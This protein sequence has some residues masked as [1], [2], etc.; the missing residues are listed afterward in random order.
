MQDKPWRN[1]ELRECEEA[2]PSL[3]ESDMEKASRL[4]KAK[5]GAGKR[6]IPPKSSSGR[7]KKKREGKLWN[8]WRRWNRVA[9]GRNKLARRC[10]S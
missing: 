7:D 10:S 2:L 3:K 5:T 8:S 4:Y 1:E 6:R 9:N